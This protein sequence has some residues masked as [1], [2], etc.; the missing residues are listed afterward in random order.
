VKDRSA[1]DVCHLRRCLLCDCAPVCERCL[2]FVC[3]AMKGSA[4]V[5]K[6]H[7]HVCLALQLCTTQA[8]NQDVY[9]LQLCTT[10]ANRMRCFH[11]SYAR[12]RP[13]RCVNYLASRANSTF[14]WD[15]FFANLH[16]VIML[17]AEVGPLQSCFCTH[18]RSRSEVAHC[19]MTK[20]RL[21]LAV[22]SAEGGDG[23]K[24][25]P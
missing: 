6:G 9:S 19:S 4:G 15:L 5:Y 20:N 18:S 11:C 2:F 3:V 16:C 24:L 8:N 10:Q 12:H 17:Y 1:E 21:L 13:T 23:C 25:P 7:A 22:G 14:K